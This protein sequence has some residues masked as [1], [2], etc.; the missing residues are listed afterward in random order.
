MQC[1]R[2]ARGRSAQVCVLAAQ[3]GHR[4]RRGPLRRLRRAGR[5]TAAR[6]PTS[7]TRSAPHRPSPRC[8]DPTDRTPMPDST[9]T[10]TSTALTLRRHRHAR[11]APSPSSR[12]TSATPSSGCTPRS[13]SP[14]RPDDEL[15]AAKADVV[16]A[17]GQRQRVPARPD[18]R[19]PGAG[20]ARRRRRPDRRPG[21]RRAVRP[22]QLGG[23]AA[24]HPRPGAGRGLGAGAGRARAS[25][26]WSSCGPAGRPR[27]RARPGRRG[28]GRGGRGG[29]RLPRA[30]RPVGDR[31]P[32]LPA[33][34]ASS[35]TRSERE[36][37]IIESAALLDELRPDL[38]KLEYPGSPQAC[39][40]LAD[41]ITARGRCCRPA[42]AFDEFV[43]VLR[44]SL[45]RGRRVRVH[46]RPRGLEGR[47]RA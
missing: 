27:R 46:R 28:A 12:W 39:R 6:S 13:G 21:R 19:R 9:A 42:S 18:L 29:R 44:I 26:S 20:P 24:G 34:R 33:A 17:A 16:G 1:V 43:D 5:P 7:P 41:A 36:D 45:R 40:R 38:L 37:V 23:R 11:T 14:T 2:R 8:P 30:G 10:A 32:D 47:G 31:E 4:L 3:R 15:V 22:G 35:S 25:S